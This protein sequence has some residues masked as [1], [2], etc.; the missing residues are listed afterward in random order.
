M[1]GLENGPKNLMKTAYD[2]ISDRLSEAN[3]GKK[4][5]ELGVELFSRKILNQEEAQNP[6]QVITVAEREHTSEHEVAHAFVAAWFGWRVLGKKARSTWGVTL[7]APGW[8]KSTQSLILEAIAISAAGEM[9]TGP[10]GCGYDRDK[11]RYLARLFC[12][13]FDRSASEDQIIGEQRSLASRIWNSY[14]F[15]ARRD[16]TLRL[17]VMG[18]L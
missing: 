14:S 9:A 13:F 12:Y 16:E 5:V 1:R 4:A 3:V 11:Q 18:D 2:R 15:G 17:A 8:F 6:A 7:T 10:E